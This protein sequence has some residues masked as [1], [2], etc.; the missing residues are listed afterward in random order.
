MPAVASELKR[1][2][3]PMIVVGGVPCAS[4]ASMCMFQPDIA[5]IGIVNDRADTKALNGRADSI[6]VSPASADEIYDAATRVLERKSE[7]PVPPPVVDARRIAWR[8]SYVNLPALEARIARRL[9]RSCGA[10]VSRDEL[11]R[12]LWDFPDEASRSVDT[13]IYRLRKRLAC[14]PGLSVVTTRQRGYSMVLDPTAPVK[15]GRR[16]S[17]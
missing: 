9:A 7:R 2:A 6:L 5:Y 10:V 4:F 13:H 15:P 12:V 11:A 3:R 8:G 14:I 1:F 17:A 16:P